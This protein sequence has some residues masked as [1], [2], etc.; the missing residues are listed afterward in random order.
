MSRS[1]GEGALVDLSRRRR[2]SFGRWARRIAV[3][4]LVLAGAVAALAAT[5]RVTSIRVEGAERLPPETVLGEAGLAGGE[6]MLLTRFGEVEER[7]E[8]LAA[9][10]GATVRRRLPSTIVIV[11]RERQP[12]A[13]L[14]GTERLVAGPEGIVFEVGSDVPLPALVGWEGEARAGARLGPPAPQLLSAFA[15]F[16]GV[17]TEATARIELGR[18]LTIVLREGT[19]VRF[20]DPVQLEAKGAAAAAVLREGAGREGPLA[21]VDVRS[22]R[23]PVTREREVPTPEPGASPTPGP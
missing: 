12:L 18:E 5:W 1:G 2:R 4:T 16:P 23:A 3:V 11:V 14:G 9:I 20:G 19:E 10:R 22:P 15:G 13:R 6:R 17:L 8:G 21:Y 7:V